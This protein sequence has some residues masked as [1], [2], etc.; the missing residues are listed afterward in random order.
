[1]GTSSSSV[2]QSKT[3]GVETGERRGARKREV[4]SRPSWVDEG[5]RP[6]GRRSESRTDPN[7]PVV[8]PDSKRKSTQYPSRTINP[9]PSLGGF[10]TRSM[11]GL[12]T[13]DEG[14]SRSKGMSLPRPLSSSTRRLKRNNR[15][16]HPTG[17]DSPVSRVKVQ[18]RTSGTNDESRAPTPYATLFFSTPPRSVQRAVPQPSGYSSGY[19][20]L[21]PSPTDLPPRVSTGPSLLLPYS[22]PFSSLLSD[23]RTPDGG[24]GGGPDLVFSGIPSH[25]RRHG[26]TAFSERLCYR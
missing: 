25:K 3:W 13:T 5:L 26:K 10:L 19:R 22:L 23:S 7:R 20:R 6:V 11:S 14:M 18:L 1:M 16:T 4:P 24:W 8:T 21:R 9:H 2:S 15:Q 12:V 17:P